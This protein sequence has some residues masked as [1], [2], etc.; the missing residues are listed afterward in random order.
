MA[1]YTKSQICNLA[2]SLL[3]LDN[4]VVDID[5]PTNHTEEVFAQYYDLVL[6]KILKRERPQFAIYDYTLIPTLYS[7]NTWHYLVPSFAVE[8]LRVNGATEGWTIEHGEILF[9]AGMPLSQSGDN[10]EIKYVGQ[11]SDTG[12]FTEEW[13]E[14]FAAELAYACA[15][16]LTQDVNMI[17]LSMQFVQKARKEY[18]TINL[19]S[20]KPRL[21][22]QNKFNAIWRR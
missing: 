11:V 9:V 16:R 15:G 3:G 2:L 19:R 21:K 5:E 6:D 14:L 10:L 12:L 7:D 1:T 13:V 8:I 18:Q 4:N 22:T 20:A 17:Q